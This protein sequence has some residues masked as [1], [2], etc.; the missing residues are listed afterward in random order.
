[1][2]IHYDI[3]RG[4]IYNICELQ[5]PG[6]EPVHVRLPRELAGG[7]DEGQHSGDLG[8]QVRGAQET[9]QEEDVLTLPAPAQM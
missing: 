8:G 7:L 5:A 2:N 1:M 3:V 4:M 6:T 9:S